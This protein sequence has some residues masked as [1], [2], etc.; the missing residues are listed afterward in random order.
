MLDPEQSIMIFRG[1][2]RFSHFIFSEIDE[3][4]EETDDCHGNATCYNTPAGSYTCECNDTY[5]GNGT[6]CKGL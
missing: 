2:L 3:C 5:A 6:H 4:A 1:S